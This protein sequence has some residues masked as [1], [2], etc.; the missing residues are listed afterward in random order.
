MIEWISVESHSDTSQLLFRYEVPLFC[1]SIFYAE[2]FPTK[3]EGTGAGRRVFNEFWKFGAMFIVFVY[4][5]NLRSH[6]IKTVKMPAP[7]S[8]EELASPRYPY[9]LLAPPNMALM[10]ASAK[11]LE[12]QGRIVTQLQGRGKDFNATVDNVNF[13]LST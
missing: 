5:C 4:L 10:N 11:S 3:W 1:F 6:L 2:A 8:L 12:E 13:R 7:N 9:K